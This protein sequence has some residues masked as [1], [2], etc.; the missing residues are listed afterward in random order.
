ME[1][2]GIID[3][4]KRLVPEI[5]V[6]RLKKTNPGDDD[7]LWFITVADIKGELQIEAADGNAPF[8]IECTWSKRSWILRRAEDVA[9]IVQSMIQKKRDRKR[10]TKP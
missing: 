2:D 7:G 10:P 5:K 1:M 3:E 9:R 4:L 8:L 6:E